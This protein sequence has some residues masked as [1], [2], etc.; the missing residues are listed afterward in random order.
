MA[1]NSANETPLVTISISTYNSADT[2]IETLESV[3]AQDYPNL[4][5]VIGDDASQ[6]NTVSLIRGWLGSN[7]RGQR[8]KRTKIIE[9]EK[10][11]GITANANRKVRAAHGAW[12][13]AIGADDTLL[14]NCVSDN[15]DFVNKNPTAKVVFSKLN[16]YKDNFKEEN[17]LYT[18]PGIINSSSI[19][20][21]DRDAKSQNKLLLFSDRIHFSPSVFY[22]RET[23][24][25][26]GGFDERF[27]LLEDYPLWLNLTR[28]SYKLYFMDRITVN[29]R[30][31]AKALNNTGKVSIINPN[32]FKQE[33]FR[34][35][36]TYKH[37]PIDV[38]LDQKFCWVTSQLFRIDFFNRPTV[39]N[40]L[41][42]SIL[43][44][45]LNPFKY[46]IWFRKRTVKDLNYNEFYNN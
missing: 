40:K 10:N 38:K 5:L 4:E 37:L 15:V 31:H 3:Y 30:S 28:N 1:M 12:I 44:V 9:V 36:Y 6:D 17:F 24:I 32:Y 33:R 26:V 22:H 21:P 45:Y 7:N 34:R 46:L 39:I 29:Y 25:S 14:P 2:V 20:S 8:F 41:L 35:M 11:T 42:H 13:K 27:R 23:V 16:I 19:F 43:T 18:A